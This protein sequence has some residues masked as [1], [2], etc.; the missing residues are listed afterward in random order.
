MFDFR[1]KA[2]LDVRLGS[3]LKCSIADTF[4]VKHPHCF[5]FGTYATTRHTTVN[6]QQ[7]RFRRATSQ[8]CVS[9]ET[10]TVGGSHSGDAIANF[11]SIKTSHL[12]NHNV[13]SYLRSHRR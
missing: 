3:V 8:R 12:E 2:V 7:L 10:Y 9:R 4:H 6:P 1:K 5:L 13:L 11:P